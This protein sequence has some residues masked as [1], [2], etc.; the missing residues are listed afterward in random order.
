[1]APV[2]SVNRDFPFALEACRIAAGARRDDGYAETQW[3]RILMNLCCKADAVDG[4]WKQDRKP[5][6]QKRSSVRR[7]APASAVRPA[8]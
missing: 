7:G 4:G 1:M 2:A 5:R 6:V 8:S 3:R